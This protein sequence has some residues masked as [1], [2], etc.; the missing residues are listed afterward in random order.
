M[1]K[2]KRTTLTLGVLLVIFGALFIAANFIPSFKVLL[3]QANTWPFII[4]AVAV[5]LL[6]LG[7][8]IGVPDMAVPAVIV[9]GIGAILWWQNLTGR[10]ETWSYMWALIPG[11]SGLG[12]LLAKAL[13][14]KERYNAWN[15][16]NTIG[17]S[18]VLFV[19]FGAFFGGF[20]FMGAYWPVALILVGVL[21]GLRTFIRN[22]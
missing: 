2:S 21:L 9:A 19:I 1:D 7:L 15:A 10:W 6:V 8:I 12:M 17:T 4:E 18:I 22:R 5:G 3:E 14:G 20:K 16:L 11:F 13:G